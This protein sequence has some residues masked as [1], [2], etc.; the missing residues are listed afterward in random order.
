MVYCEWLLIVEKLVLSS[1]RVVTM[2]RPTVRTECSV[3]N[4]TQRHGGLNITSCIVE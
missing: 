1:G 2:V 3:E 4:R